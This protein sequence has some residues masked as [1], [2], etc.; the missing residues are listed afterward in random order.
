[1]DAG[2]LYQNAKIKSRE[3]ALMTADRLQRIADASSLEEAVKLLVEGGYPAARHYDEMLAAAEKEVTLFFR[4]SMTN[5]YGLECFLV[6]ND[7]HNAKVAAKSEYFGGSK[8]GYKPE[9]TLATALLE[10]SI[11]KEDYSL[12]PAEMAAGFLAIKKLRDLGALYPSAVDVTFD[13]ALFRALKE[14][15]KKASPVIKRYFALL[16]DFGNL[17]VVYRA[18]R[19]G[20]TREKTDELLLPAGNLSSKEW[21]KIFDVG[22]DESVDYMLAD[23]TLKE[24]IRRLRE[25]VTAYEVYTDDALLT[26]LKKERFDMFSPAPVVGFYIGKLREIKNVRLLLARVANGA[27]KEKVKS[28]MRELYV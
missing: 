19:A 8:E 14:D 13:K 12:L 9:G 5:G 17:S 23:K 21:L 6:A 11:K 4:E 26:L 3:T 22:I 16:A 20:F 7:Y 15:L 27:D 28:R 18:K 24:G 2:L 10:E 25:S 1:M